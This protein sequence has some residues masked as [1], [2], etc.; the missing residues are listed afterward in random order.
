MT[1]V[2]TQT[3]EVTTTTTTTTQDQQLQ[4]LYKVVLTKIRLSISSGNFTPDSLQVILTKVVETI[5]EFAETLPFKL[6]GEEKRT[7]ALNLTQL[8][9]DDLHNNGQLDN[10]TYGWLKLS[11]TFMSPVL[12]TAIK[13]IWKKGQEISQDIKQN[14]YKGC[15]GRNICK[16]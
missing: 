6:S 3:P 10:E 13:M 2:V 11:I 7:I 4:E 15:F 5:Q 8:I 12:F 1:E 14:G 16:K 9:I